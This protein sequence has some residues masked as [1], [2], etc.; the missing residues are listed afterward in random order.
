MKKKNQYHLLLIYLLLAIVVYLPLFGHLETIPIQKWDE[1]RVAENAYEMYSTGDLLVPTF[2]Y[3]PDMWNTK[4]PLL[5][6]IQTATM[7]ILG[8]TVLAIRLPSAFAALF[9]C[10]CL[11]VFGARYM[12]NHLFGPIAV[13]VLITI[14]GYVHTHVTRT[15]DYESLLILCTT[16]SALA[17]FAYCES[18]KPKY[19][20]WFFAASVL[21]VMTKS[22]L[23]LLFFPAMFLYS[24]YSRRFI[25]LITSRHLY[26]GILGFVCLVGG[27]YLLR[28]HY[29]P[30][31]LQVVYKNELG[32]RYL[33]TLEKHQHS[34][35]Y[36]FDR[37]R[38]S[39][40]VY[41]IYLI[42]VGI[43]AGLLQAD[44]RLKRIAIYMT[45]L[46]FTFFLVISN[47]QTK[48]EWYDAPMYPFIA[49]LAAIPIY[50]IADFVMH[51]IG[52]V[53]KKPLLYLL[54]IP[55]LAL[56]FDLPYRD[57]LEK[58]YLPEDH[59]YNV[60]DHA[61]RAYLHDVH[62]GDQELH[63][64]WILHEG[65]YAHVLIYQNLLREQ[66]MSLRYQPLNEVLE[67]DT[68]LIYQRSLYDKLQD[69]FSI[70]NLPIDGIQD[71]VSIVKVHHER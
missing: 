63:A 22:I 21:A 2:E 20:Y 44:E 35:W 11:L 13:L 67:G 55:A 51:K 53:D 65:Y 41:W 69:R 59:I 56:L 37:M 45:M 23:I 16:A 30:G 66:G 32:G 60:E 38:A 14:G 5:V 70:E 54:Y 15:G 40:I 24:L 9:T 1:S 47:A 18:G 39:T 25:P 17:F 3:E 28:E 52:T 27:Y 58:T 12:K 36:Y 64:R 19:L 42:P 46:I 71:H 7:H 34:F 68:L 31:Y 61:I 48:L 6:W 10:I 4:P 33:G 57:I 26:I 8:P 43:V 29:N 62:R 50:L 49:I